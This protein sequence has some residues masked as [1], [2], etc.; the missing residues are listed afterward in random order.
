MRTG[1]KLLCICVSYFL[2]LGSNFEA[3]QPPTIRVAVNMTTVESSPI[4]VAAQNSTDVR[5]DLSAGGIPALLEGTADAA[6]TSETQALLR[7]IER[8][9]LRIVMTV[10]ECAYRIVARRSAGVSKLADLRGKRIGTPINTSAH[11]YLSRALRTA[12]LA[13]SDVTVVPLAV[14]DMARAIANGAVNAIAGWEPAS[15][16]ALAALGKDAAVLQ[17]PGLYRELFNLNTTTAVLNDR[18]RRLLL[19][20]AVR[21]IIAASVH[22]R[23]SPR[24]VWPLVSSQIHVPPG[25]IAD[26]WTHFRFPASLPQ[27]IIDVMLEEERW[28]AG[29]QHRTPRTRTA[30]QT[31]V[32]DSVLREASQ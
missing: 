16:D 25:S 8:P 13:E 26:V 32:D 2:V 6:T 1:L 27:D 7:S 29:V 5:I 24:P 28:V 10:A 31:L 9:D 20:N 19:V 21:D 23:G 12:G 22:V 3:A 4:F 14:P 17:P 15:H 18:A 30:L 11:Y